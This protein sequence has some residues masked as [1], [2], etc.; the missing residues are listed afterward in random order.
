LTVL[1]LVAEGKSDKQIAAVLGLR[2]T[3]V[4]KH[5]ANLKKK[6]LAASRAEAGVRAWREGLLGREE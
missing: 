6:M 3:T 2:P 4:S 1:N 5:V